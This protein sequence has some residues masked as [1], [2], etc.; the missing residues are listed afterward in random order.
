MRRNLSTKPKPSR[1]LQSKG[2]FGDSWQELFRDSQENLIIEPQRYEAM[3][4]ELGKLQV[5]KEICQQERRENKRLSKKLEAVLA[6][7]V[8]YLRNLL[9]KNS[10]AV[11]YGQDR[12]ESLS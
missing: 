5:W 12:R 3:I 2:E 11:D 4:Y 7:E 10:K 8:D 6:R 1:P 9:K